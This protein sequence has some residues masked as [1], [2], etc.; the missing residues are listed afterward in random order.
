MPRA[1]LLLSDV[2]LTS[3]P[4][5]TQAK[6]QTLNLEIIE[7]HLHSRQSKPEL[8]L[9]VNHKTL[10]TYLPSTLTRTLNPNLE[11]VET[12]PQSGHPKRLKPDSQSAR[13]TQNPHFTPNSWNPR[14]YRIKAIFCFLVAGILFQSKT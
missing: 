5:S 2:I 6:M 14:E 1:L 10:N 12:Q 7:T 13:E 9:P 4:T 11:I 3:F 8:S